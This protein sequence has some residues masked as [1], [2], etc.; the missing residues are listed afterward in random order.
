LS[1]KMVECRKLRIAHPNII[2]F[3]NFAGTY[4]I[5]RFIPAFYNHRRLKSPVHLKI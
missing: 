3:A 1:G 5:K 2:P 4:C